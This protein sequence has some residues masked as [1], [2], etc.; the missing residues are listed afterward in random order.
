[1]PEP[2]SLMKDFVTE[3]KPM[4][5]GSYEAEVRRYHKYDGKL[6]TWLVADQPNAGDNIYFCNFDPKSQ[7]FAGRNLHFTLVDGTEIVL[8]AP[9]HSNSQALFDDTGVGVRDRCLTFVVIAKE[10]VPSG[11]QTIYRGVVYADKEP[12]VGYFN[13]GETLAKRLTNQLGVMLY[14]YSESQGGSSSSPIYPKE[15]SDG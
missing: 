13:R 15:G 1:M 2:H 11:R 3:R 6:G 7:G 5:C 12:Q 4:T 10:R 8:P 9:W 14:C